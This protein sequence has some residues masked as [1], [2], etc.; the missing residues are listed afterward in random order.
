M[1]QPPREMLPPPTRIVPGDGSYRYDGGPVNPVPRPEIVPPSPIEPPV[2]GQING[3]VASLMPVKI[4]KFAYPA[5]GDPP[6]QTSF[7]AG[8]TIPVK[9]P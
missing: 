8:Q 6:A 5:Y 4:S 7:A 9:V 3:R 2:K 1:L